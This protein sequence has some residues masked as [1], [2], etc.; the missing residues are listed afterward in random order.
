MRSEIKF[1][2]DGM[3]GSLARWLRIIGFDT[4]YFSGRDKYFLSYRAR[5][6][7]RIVLTRDRNFVSQNR[8]ISIFIESENLRLQLR[9]VKKKSNLKFDREKFFTLCSLCNLPLEKKKLEDVLIYVPEYVGK[10]Q[11]N[12]SQCKRCSR[13]YWQ[14]THYQRM[15]EF[16][17]SVEADEE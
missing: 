11:K 5:N 10:T 1:I 17:N 16:I 15:L 7:G 9:E 3:L 2:A 8:P 13:I 12:F 14:G 4:E 6:Q